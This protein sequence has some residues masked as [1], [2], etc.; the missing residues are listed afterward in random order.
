M[1]AACAH[2]FVAPR[3]ILSLR[4]LV[5]ML[6]DAGY[7]EE[8]DYRTYITLFN[9]MSNFMCRPNIIVHLD[10]KP[11]ESLRRIKMRCAHRCCAPAWHARLLVASPQQP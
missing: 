8:R 2:A 3:L 1:L 9:N 11:E 10:V 6:K 4:C 7:M 5:Q